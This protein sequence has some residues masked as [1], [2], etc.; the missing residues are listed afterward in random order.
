MA[1]PHAGTGRFPSLGRSRSPAQAAWR[2][3]LVLI[4]SPLLLVALAAP[5]TAHSGRASSA[6]PRQ[7]AGPAVVVSK[8]N[9]HAHLDCRRGASLCTEVHDSEQVFGEGV[10]VGHDEPSLLFY[11][12]EPGSGNRARY[13]LRLPSD[14]PPQPLPGKRAYNFQ[15]H[16]GLWFGMALCDTESSPEQLSTC[17]PGSDANIV[18][19]AVS[20]NHPGTAFMEM[21]FYPPGWVA[22]PSGISCDPTR[23]CAAIAIFSLLQDPV[24]GTQQNDTCLNKVGLEPANFAFITRNGRP[25]APP[26]PLDATVGTFTPNPDTD[27]F[28]RSGDVLSLTMHDTAH[29]LR[30]QI[31]DHTTGQGGSMTASAANGFGH[32]A[33][34]PSPS[35]D[36]TNLP[37]DFHPMYSTSSEQTRVPWAAHSFNIA[38]SDEIGHFDYC[39]GIDPATAR[40]TGTEG[41][42]RDIEAADGDDNICF[43]AA[44][45][46]RVPVSGCI[47]SNTGF[48][49]VSYKE[50]W[51]DGNRGLHPTAWQF[52]SPLTGP[53]YDVN[54][55]RVAFEA[56]LPRIEAADFGGS[57][58]R[59][60]GA[61]CTRIPI[62]DDGQPA[63]F[64]PFYSK[65]FTSLGCTWVWGNHVPG[66]SVDD[67]GRNAQYG[68]LLRLAYTG[69]GGTVIHRFN[70][71]RGVLSHNPCPAR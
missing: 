63:D 64:Y 58:N 24:H 26:N 28:M 48:D 66:L 34:A 23:W 10:Y 20:P 12:N 31:G 30:V 32:V 3:L 60:T 36:C 44:A 18:D 5:T 55:S 6:S 37:Y 41:A 46:T 42:G 51:P 2:R 57:C 35:T 16:P 21:Q 50:V 8:N 22:W 49:G 39:N 52:T 17:R 47:D 11:S 9:H 25:H 61:G 1:A 54:Y 27:L 19:P 59:T 65:G 53:A 40:C 4:G 45:S 68:S 43:P 29:G 56:D 38:F 67:F 69:P 13:Q 15:L 14:P 70:D 71:F 62:T 33:F 7:A